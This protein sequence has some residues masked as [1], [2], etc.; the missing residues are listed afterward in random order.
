MGSTYTRQSSTEIVDGEVIQASDFNNEFEQLVSAFAVSTGHSHDGT[1]AEGGPVTK[2]LGTAITIGDG[3]AGTD[4]AVTFDGETS[5][6]VLTWMEDEDHFKFSDDVVIDST[7]RLYLND[8]GGEYIYGDGTDLYLVSGADINIPANIGMTFGDDGEKI[9]GDGTDLTISGNNINL[10]ATADVNIPSGVGVTFATT[11]KIESDGTDLSITV[12]SGGDINIPADIGVTFGDD[13]EKIEGDGTD[14][15]ITGNNINLTA[16]ADVVIPADVGITFGSGEKIEGDS[17][18][19]TVTSGADINLTATSDVNIPSGVGVTFGDDGEKIEG[20]GTNLTIETS[21]N[22]TIDAAADIILDAGGADVTLK[23]DGTTFGS[24]T[25]SSGELVIKSGSTPTTALTFSGANV[26]GAGTYTG[27]GTMTT[28]GNIVIPDGGNIGSASD[29]DA[30]SIASTGV[31]TFSQSPV[32]PDGGVPLDDLDIDGATDIGADLTTSD[33]I[34]VDDGAGGT[35]RKAALSRINTL[36]QTAGGFP[37]TALDIDGGTDIGEAI[38]DADLFIIDNGAGGTNRKVEASRIKTYIGSDFSNPASAD[39]DSLGTSSLE[40]SDLYLADG[41][42]IYF[43]NDQ[44]ITLTHAA[45]DGLVLK[46]VGTGDGKEPSLT[47]QAGDNDIAVNDVLGSIFFQAPDEGAGTDAVLVAAGIEAVS[48][49]N[50]AADNNATKLSFKTAA[51]EAASEKMSLSSAGLLTVADDIVFKDGGTIG[52]SSATD[53][54]TVSSGGI[55]TF[56]DDIII[57]DGGTIGSA[58]ATGAM[59]VASTGIVTFVDDILIKDGGTIGSASS[60]SAITVA[61]TG[62]VTFVD[63]ILIKDGGTI[64]S[65]SSTGAITVASTGIVTFVDD[66]LIKDGGTI[67]SASSTGAITIAS[68]GIVTFVDDI[69]IKDAGTI[70]SASDTDAIS[71]SSGGVV[72]ISATT[73]NTNASD[74]ALTVAGGA[75]IAADLSVGDDLRLISDSAV[76]NF[77]ADSDVTLTHAAD[78]SLTLAGSTAAQ[79]IMSTGS[80]LPNTNTDTSNSGSVTLDFKTY[81]NHVLTFTGNVT[82]ANPTT[83]TAGQSGIIVCI[84]DGTG[85]RTLSLGTDYETAGGAGITLSTAANAVDV[86]PYF[87]KASG[88]V[89]LGAVQKAFS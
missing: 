82:L 50:F 16:T 89:Q 70:G 60:T 54:M 34:I 45:D 74:G 85:S 86:I 31:V 52:V 11:E 64:G 30:I 21:N 1:T 9:E 42:V 73:A 18:D 13:G 6:G 36:V 29:T 25:N 78:A 80:I 65:A 26:T 47:F 48:E 43:G 35:N 69:V 72:N 38:V 33:L 41:G 28:G 55:V 79:L 22:V 71:I 8:E 7:K 81:Q 76:L 20:D 46:H 49:G 62:I 77:G 84:Q 63:D 2:L 68:T 10:T 83:E 14:L 23:D 88:S 3:T 39:G 24:L 51:S 58:S 4:I 32:F 12:G 40:W 61:S 17:T 66:I 59:T 37:L 87:V 57:K 15:T 53:A 19:L 27:G 5:D 75:G 56:K 67:G 44:E